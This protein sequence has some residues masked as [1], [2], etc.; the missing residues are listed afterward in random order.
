M[1]VTALAVAVVARRSLRRRYAIVQIH[2]PPDF[3]VAAALIPK[4]LGARAILD[5]HDLAP[6]MFEMRFGRGR[7]SRLLSKALLKVEKAAVRISDEVITVHE[8]YRRELV[9]TGIPIGE[10]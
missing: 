8:P 9:R 1:G 2:T 4:L 10:I 7:L 3:L 6:D 5:I